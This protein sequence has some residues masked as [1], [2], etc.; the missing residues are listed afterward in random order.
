MASFKD[1]LI[2]LVSS[3][4]N[5]RNTS[6]QNAYEARKLSDH[7]HRTIYKSGV[8]NKIIRIKAGH[9]LKDTIQF[10]STADEV[11]YSKG[12]E[13]AV[14]QAARWMLAFGRGIIV[15]HETGDALSDPRTRPLDPQRARL[16]VFSGDMVMPGEVGRDLQGERYQM[17]V[18]Y[19][20]R[21]HEIHHT[22][23]IDFTYVEVP[24]LEAHHYRYG[25]MSEFELA[26]DQIMNDGVMQRAV[27]RIVEK[28]SSMFYKIKGF[29]A[30]MQQG[31][32]GPMVDYVTHME[33]VRGILSAGIIDA[34]DQLEVV[35]QTL[36]NLNDADQI[37]LRR[38]AMV[39]GLSRLT[40]VG[41]APTGLG[42]SGEAEQQVSQDM[43]E[44]LQ[45]D[46]LL[47]PLQQLFVAL[48]MGPPEFRENQGETP[49]TR[50]AYDNTAADVA[51]KLDA[52][53]EDAA[54]YLQDK[55]VVPKPDPLAD[56]FPEKPDPE[57]VEDGGL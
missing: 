19:H 49:T 26:Y 12:P 52:M 31:K 56:L 41:E 23:V 22:R 44:A 39:T 33:D 8:G 54:A 51:T 43:I 14:K 18:T 57:P 2:S 45:S 27:P 37:T 25:G 10:D 38:L 21:G 35:T 20:V 15:L 4:V 3:L 7:E 29:K 5:R 16:S 34:E 42:V 30:A 9:A 53:G 11:R 28:A 24:E 46:Y 6:A 32:D 17:P 1:G 48:G 36:T 50:V 13:Q 40:L 55:D 47:A